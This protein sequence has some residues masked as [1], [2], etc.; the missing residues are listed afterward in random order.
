MIF[1]FTKILRYFYDIAKKHSIH[2]NTGISYKEMFMVLDLP[3][4]HDRIAKIAD[5]SPTAQDKL[6]RES[7]LYNYD[8]DSV[9]PQS[10]LEDVYTSLISDAYAI[11]IEFTVPLGELFDSYYM[12]DRFLDICTYLMPAPLYRHLDQDPRLYNVLTN[13]LDGTSSD[14][15]DLLITYIRYL[16]LDADRFSDD[17]TE[18]SEFLVDKIRTA[19]QYK[20]VL[21]NI[22]TMDEHL[23]RL[24]DIDPDDLTT[25]ITAIKNLS[26][27]L[28]EIVRRLQEAHPNI[29]RYKQV[30]RLINIYIA[31]LTDQDKIPNYAWMFYGTM[32]DALPLNMINTSEQRL[33]TFYS[34]QPL[35]AEYFVKHQKVLSNVKLVASVV[36]IAAAHTNTDTKTLDVGTFKTSLDKFQKTL[37]AQQKEILTPEQQTLIKTLLATLTGDKDQ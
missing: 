16:G 21:R 35:H 8:V 23:A 26:D 7:Y 37:L 1:Y 20:T 29:V 5:L 31:S 11:G 27:T 34:T 17:L 6:Q 30:L 10:V 13:L 36:R 9:T 22:L 3:T 15:D 32:T 28:K 24:P 25:Y 33:Y 2:R 4:H 18:I 14:E 12:L 19:P